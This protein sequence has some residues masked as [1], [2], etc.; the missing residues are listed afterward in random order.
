MYQI[1]YMY[2][3]S[4]GP[5]PLSVWKTAFDVFILSWFKAP[6]AVYLCEQ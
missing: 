6:K 2:D 1:S 3:M 5:L 4:R